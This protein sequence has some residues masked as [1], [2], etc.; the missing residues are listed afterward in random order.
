MRYN[1]I[2]LRYFISILCF[3]PK[4]TTTLTKSQIGGSFNISHFTNRLRTQ[5]DPQKIQNAAASNSAATI[6]RYQQTG[7]TE[8]YEG[9]H[10]EHALSTHPD[11]AFYTRS[12]HDVKSPKLRG[13]VSNSVKRATLAHSIDAYERIV[14]RLRL[15][16][17]LSRYFRI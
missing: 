9:A 6:Q 3:F 16:S 2:G 13:K 5:G 8:S 14:G 1:S 17:E 4:E 7:R 15:H 10:F 12:I 11:S